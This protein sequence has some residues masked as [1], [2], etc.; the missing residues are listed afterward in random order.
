M[1][2][3]QK[4]LLSLEDSLIKFSRAIMPSTFGDVTP[5]LHNEW[6][7]ILLDKA[8]VDPEAKDKGLF[9][10]HGLG[11]LIYKEGLQTED[12]LP[13]NATAED[14]IKL[15]AHNK[16]IR[17]EA[18]LNKQIL[19]V[20]PRNSAKSTIAAGGYPLYHSVYFRDDV[21]VLFQCKTAKEAKKRLRKIANVLNY[22]DEFATCFGYYGEDNSKS[23]VEWNKDKITIRVVNPLIPTNDDGSERIVEW[24]FEA[25][26][27]GQST[28]GLKEVDQRI[29]LYILD[30]PEDEDNTKT[31]D[32]MKDNFDKFLSIKAGVVRN[33]KQIVIG[34]PIHQLCLVETLRRMTGWTAKVYHTIVEETKTSI[35]EAVLPYQEMIDELRSY[36][37]VH[38]SSKFYSERQ[39][40]ITGDEDQVFREEDLMWW[41]GYHTMQDGHG[42]LTI[43][44]MGTSE[45]NLK[46]LTDADGKPQHEKVPVNTH[47]GIDPAS[48]VGK[49]ADFSVTLANCYDVQERQ[50]IDYIFEKRVRPTAHADNIEQ[51]A[52]KYKPVRTTPEADGYQ[53]SLRDILKRKTESNP[54]LRLPGITIKWTTKGV[55]K[56]ERIE[57]MEE[58]TSGKKLYLKRG[59]NNFKNELLLF[60]R[61]RKNILDAWFWSARKLI[62]PVHTAIKKKVVQE[63]EEE[64]VSYMG[65]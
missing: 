65:M 63:E 44:H 21:Y 58:F 51:T 49:R 28:R 5:P 15:S 13:D 20:A 38:K 29:T 14:F 22:S 54:N 34:T 59:M 4:I 23:R 56:I 36:S 47:L 18:P 42:V 55:P 26:G 53:E 50:F 57:T 33:G 30:D 31:E 16:K 64:T 6:D 2:K 19:F 45:E 61:G 39:C 41:D 46:L 24:T 48:S 43:T 27:Y 11:G 52:L 1:T 12:D 8:R 32:T 37:S 25:K 7:D 40:L 62:K 17:D 60:P 9:D 35:W 3:K 10:G